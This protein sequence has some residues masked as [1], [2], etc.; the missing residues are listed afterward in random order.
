MANLIS[1]SGIVAA[2][3]A[4]GGG[5]SGGGLIPISTLTNPE[6]GIHPN[7]GLTDSA[8]ASGHPDNS[9]GNLRFVGWS[10]LI[11]N[12]WI[13]LQGNNPRPSP[14]NI[15]SSA[16]ETLM[17]N[18]C[19]PRD[20][21]GVVGRYINGITNIR[22]ETDAAVVIPEWYQSTSQV[23]TNNHDMHMM[24]SD[25]GEMKH[26]S[27]GASLD[28]LPRT[29]TFGTGFLYRTLTW[30]QRK[31]R[32]YRVMIGGGGYF[33]GLWID[34]KAVIKATPNYPL[35]FGINGDS[36][37]D[38][39]ALGGDYSASQSGTYP[40]GCY[41]TMLMSSW[42]SFHL[43]VPVFSTAQG[44]TGEDNDNATTGGNVTD[45]N[46]NRSSAM[47]TDSRVNHVNDNYGPQYYIEV[48]IGSWN[49]GSSL[50]NPG[51]YQTRMVAR[52]DKQAAR[53]GVNGRLS[54]DFKTIS[55]SIQPVVNVGDG[56][57]LKD[58]QSLEQRNV[59]GLRPNNSLGHIEFRFANQMWVDRSSTGSRTPYTLSDNLH[60]N[61]SGLDTTAGYIANEMGNMLIPADYVVKTQ[62]GTVRTSDG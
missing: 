2:G 19:T 3:T 25:G 5:G 27:S 48:S 58:A 31:M 46:G 50:P 38:D 53:S 14:D 16:G 41:Q 49:D 23:V 22:F 13:N 18:R 61:V 36:W 40:T 10:D 24:V 30:S 55:V 21:S 59:P 39:A 37:S 44:G 15:T 26:L 52:Y 33:R 28:G 8:L 56:S 1:A 42:L 60:L 9:A 47:W 32:R 45:Y 43:G 54:T 35:V 29:S 11:A 20:A 17:G 12:K 4:L 6:L 62:H 7:T 34:A 57:T 51:D